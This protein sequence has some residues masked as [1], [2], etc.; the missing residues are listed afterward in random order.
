MRAEDIVGLTFFSLLV[1][2]G[3]FVICGGNR[4]NPSAR[5][6]KWTAIGLAIGGLAFLLFGLLSSYFV[7]TSPRVEATGYIENLR[8][9][10]GKGAGSY[11]FLAVNGG[12]TFALH[13]Q[14][15]GYGIQ[16]G[17]L[18]KVRFLPYNSSVLELTMLSGSTQGWHLTESDGSTTYLL[19][20]LAGVACWWGAFRE[21][22]KLANRT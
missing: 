9:T 10:T 14:Y 3:V 6:P 4:N 17:D 18:A 8:R 13:A 20:S 2:G 19:L 22:R 7:H 12:P 16:Q 1:L 5:K 11:F 21:Y 15:H